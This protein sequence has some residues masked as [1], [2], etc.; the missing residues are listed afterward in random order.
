MSKTAADT[1]L[2]TRF[3]DVMEKF[4]VD[5]PTFM[6]T[7]KFILPKKEGSSFIKDESLRRKMAGGEDFR[8]CVASK[9]DKGKWSIKERKVQGFSDESQII[10]SG[11]SLEGA[12]TQLHAI[13]KS[14]PAEC[15][16]ADEN[17]LSYPH[18]KMVAELLNIS[19]SAEN[20]ADAPVRKTVKTA[21]T[22]NS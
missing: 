7:S 16:R 14:M 10:V 2:V 13:E 22:H 18:Y 20:T 11:L 9:N 17:N 4:G 3:S 21:T 1:D 12:V 8:V 19:I 15:R 5:F 6:Q